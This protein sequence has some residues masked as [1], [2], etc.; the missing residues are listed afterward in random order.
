L[1]I[2]TILWKA[3]YSQQFSHQHTS[4]KAPL[5]IYWMCSS[6]CSILNTKIPQSHMPISKQNPPSYKCLALIKYLPSYIFAA[7]NKTHPATYA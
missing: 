7:L 1:Q 4:W 5:I 3:G 6:K 2:W